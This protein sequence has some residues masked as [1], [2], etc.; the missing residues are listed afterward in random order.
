M[1]G[2]ETGF[3]KWQEVMFLNLLQ[4]G[5]RD[6]RLSINGGVDNNVQRLRCI[7]EAGLYVINGPRER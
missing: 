1:E 4:L 3:C 2:C 5:R 7:A 6:E